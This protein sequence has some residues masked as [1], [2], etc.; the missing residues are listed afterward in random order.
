MLFSYSSYEMHPN[1]IP[2]HPSIHP[3]MLNGNVSDLK[4]IL[5]CIYDLNILLLELPPAVDTINL[6]LQYF[7]HATIKLWE[8]PPSEFPP[9]PSPRSSTCLYSSPATITTSAS[10]ATTASSWIRKPLPA[11]SSW[12]CWR[13]WR[14]WR[15]YK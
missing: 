1:S 15:F 8:L 3:S 2:S 9:S 7:N 12:R 5:T 11:P 14:I 4:V 13:V 10:P 6:F